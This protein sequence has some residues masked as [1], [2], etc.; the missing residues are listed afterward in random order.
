M[1]DQQL[2]IIISS[3]PVTLAAVGALIVAVI[4]ARKT[5]AVE[6]KVD[7]VHVLSNDNLSKATDALAAANLTIKHLEHLNTALV[8][9]AK[10]TPPKEK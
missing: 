2:T 1:T 8:S 10:E 7:A 5:A 4:N 6:A 9:P 3:I